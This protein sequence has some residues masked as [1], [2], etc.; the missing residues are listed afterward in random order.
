MLQVIGWLI[1]GAVKITVSL[2][3]VEPGKGLNEPPQD[4]V[5]LIV[6]NSLML[7]GG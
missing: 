3:K 2:F 4:D 1:T 5:Q 7:R 6:L